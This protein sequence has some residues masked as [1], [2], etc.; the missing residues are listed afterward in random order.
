MNARLLL[1]VLFAFAA[2]A[3]PRYGS[4][5]EY[6]LDNSSYALVAATD[7]SVFLEL[8]AI[9][10]DRVIENVVLSSRYMPPEFEAKDLAGDD[11][12]EFI[13]RTRDGGTGFA[14]THCAVYGIVG[15]HIRRLG[16][17]VEDRSAESWPDSEYREKLSGKVSFPKRGEL[18]YRYTRS[19]TK[20]GKTTTKSVTERFSFN[21]KRMEYE[22]AKKP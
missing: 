15:G 5:V 11:N 1:A 18:I 12:V 16:D 9:E 10:G 7:L 13:I 3:H 8:R 4:A 22:Q 20:R 17:F 21:Q 19:V 2:N 14:E 6:R